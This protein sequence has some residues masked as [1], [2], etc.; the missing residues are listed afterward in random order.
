MLSGANIQGLRAVAPPSPPNVYGF[1]IKMNCSHL[2]LRLTMKF[3]L[4][5][6]NLCSFAQICGHGHYEVWGLE[7]LRTL[8]I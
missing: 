2:K 1:L 7:F 4:T 5:Q 8:C 3:E 6:I